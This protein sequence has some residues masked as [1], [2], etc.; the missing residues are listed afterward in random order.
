MTRSLPHF[1][2][3]LLLCTG[4]VLLTTQCEGDIMTTPDEQLVV[5]GF[6]DEGSAP[7]VTVTLSIPVSTEIQHAESLEDNV[8]TK[9]Q[10]SISDGRQ[11]VN[12]IGRYNKTYFPPFIYST[13]KMRGKAGGT[14][15]ITVDYEDHH[16][17]ATTTIPPVA[18]PDSIVMRRVEGVAVP[19]SLYERPT[20]NGQPDPHYYQPYI[21]MHD[22]P[23]TKDY[24]AVFSSTKDYSHLYLIS[25][26]GVIDDTSLQDT[27]VIPVFRGKRAGDG[28]PSSYFINGEEVNVKFARVDSVSYKILKDYEDNLL[29][30]SNL[31][32]QY[33]H[34]I[35]TNIQGGLGYW[36]G[37][38]ATFAKFTAGE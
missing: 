24:Y 8:I 10:V 16:V 32:F 19:D 35:N 14:Y 13:T 31:F 18:V 25:Q 23:A 29:F 28:N 9:A 1:I 20:A 37:C 22:D 5:E 26:M 15:T 12:M 2:S 17:T 4:L 33:T 11:T 27:S 38:G 6:I 30:G 3:S 21:Y 7:V 36:I 34:N